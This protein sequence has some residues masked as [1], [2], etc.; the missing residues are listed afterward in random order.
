MK[1][2]LMCNF[3]GLLLRY[4]E[5]IIPNHSALSSLTFYHY[6]DLNSD[7]TVSLHNVLQ[8][9]WLDFLLSIFLA[10]FSLMVIQISK[11]FY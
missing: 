1:G 6:R 7:L 8:I 2:G 5:V 9:V 4:N 10:F 11:H 3:T